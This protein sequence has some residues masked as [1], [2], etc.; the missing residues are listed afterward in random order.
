MKTLQSSLGNIETIKLDELCP[1]HE[2][3]LTQIK[4]EKHVVVGWDENGEAIK[5][6]RRIP[7]YCEQCQEEQKKQD[8]EDAIIDILNASI[9]Q[10]TYN[11]L[12]RDSTIPEDLKTASFDNF[13][14]ETPEEKQ[15][16]DF[17]KNQTQKYLD[18][19]NGN[20]LLTGTTGV[21]KTH[22]AVSLAKELNEAY[23][24]KGEPKSV[25][26][27]NLTEILREI[28]ESFKFT[29]KEGYYSRMLKEVDYLIL[30]DL[31]VKLGNSSG[32]SKSAWEEEFIFDVLSHRNNTIITTNLSNDEIANLYSE[33][34]ASRVRT[35][36]DG[37]YFKVFSIKDKR[38]SIN[39]LKSNA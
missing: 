35:G 5:E 21:G 30:D 4:K 31:G 11:V 34:V 7:P 25:L 13:I 22:L 17:V 14:I 6:V 36:L 9:Y 15:M 3:Q 1:K 38:Y 24:A 16:L 8:E 19:M 32:Q 39:R 26:F 33:R 20:T 10:K 23:R 18:G 27:I 29:S 28:R 37:N 2:I 12:M